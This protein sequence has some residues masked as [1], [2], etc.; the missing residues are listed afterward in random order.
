MEQT[1]LNLHFVTVFYLQGH[2]VHPSRKQEQSALELPG[3]CCSTRTLTPTSSF[4]SPAIL[5]FA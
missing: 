3:S 5:M 4:S 2:P 1:E